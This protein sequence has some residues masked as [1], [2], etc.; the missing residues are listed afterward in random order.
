M[1]FLDFA[2]TKEK[3]KEEEIPFNVDYLIKELLDFG[4]NQKEDFK[5]RKD[6]KAKS[7]KSNDENTVPID[8]YVPDEYKDAS[9]T[10]IQSTVDHESPS[11]FRR[12]ERRM[13]N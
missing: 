2:N 8:I 4:K 1:G 13:V 11:K 10:N 3:S 6:K 5:T 9:L 12:K 7:S